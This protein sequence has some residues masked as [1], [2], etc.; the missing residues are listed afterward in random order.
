MAGILITPEAEDDLI[1]LWVSIARD[2][3]AAADLVYQA[4]QTIFETLVA[5]PNIDTPY[6]SKLSRLKGLCFFPINLLRNHVIYYRKNTEGIE[7]IRILHAHMKKH[8]RGIRLVK[9]ESSPV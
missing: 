6:H 8:K 7:I 2:T 9:G 3:P 1:H 4:A 5:M